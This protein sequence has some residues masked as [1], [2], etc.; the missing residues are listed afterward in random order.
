[1]IGHRFLQVA[2]VCGVSC[3]TT[4]AFAENAERPEPHVGDRW[5]WQHVN[6]LAKEK[7]TTKIEDVIE[8]TETEIRTRLRTKGQ[9]NSAVAA[10]TRDWNQVDMVTAQ[11]D[12]YLKR[13]E[14]PC[15]VGKAWQSTADK[16]LFANG[17]HG[18]FVIKGEVASF[19]KVSVPAGTFDAYKIVL[20]MDAVSTDEDIR[21]GQTKEIHWYAPLVKNDVKVDNTFSRD[22]RIR[23]QDIFELVEYSLR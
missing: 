7:D 4:L 1:M 13:F 16:M 18:K 15:Q 17:K 3:F 8:V 14:F 6:G 21:V 23:S 12:P 5:A 19:E 11:Y 22:G 9:P 2:I 10:Y 20:T